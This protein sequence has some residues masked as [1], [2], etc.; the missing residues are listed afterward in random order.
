[1]QA[2][3]VEPKF[4]VNQEEPTALCACVIVG[5]ERTLLANLAA[6]RKFT[7]DY[8]RANMAYLERARYLYTTGFFV[9][10]NSEAV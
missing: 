7:M 5:K 6:A 3:G 9:D 10:S 8:L 4:D 1:M 2:A